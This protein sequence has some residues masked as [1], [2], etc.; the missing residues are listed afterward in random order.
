MSR[1]NLVMAELLER[2]TAFLWLGTSMLG[3]AFRIWRLRT[4]LSLSYTDPKDVAYLRTVIRSSWLRGAVKIILIV[5]ALLAIRLNPTVPEGEAGILFWI[6]RVGLDIVP[7]LL[8]AEDLGV[9]AIRR[10]LGNREWI[11]RGHSL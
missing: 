10:R 7:I 2:L 1:E 11:R 6:W 4:L 9:D 5:G 8:L 3:L